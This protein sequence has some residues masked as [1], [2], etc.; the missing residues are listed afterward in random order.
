MYNDIYATSRASQSVLATNKLIRNT[1]ILLSMTL[2]FSAAT[3]VFALVT[4]APPLP[5]WAVLIGYFG[6]LFTTQ[7]LR[8]SAMGLLAV[9]ALTGFMCYTLGPII[10]Y[11]LHLHNGNQIVGMAMG[12]T[13]AIFLG[14]SAYALSSKKD[15]SFMGGFLM[16]GIWLRFLRAWAL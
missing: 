1:Y 6:L 11:Y 2:L 10:G 9:F 4:N 14:L 5:W 13:G 16:V 8:N 3:A 7:A 12:G 15:F